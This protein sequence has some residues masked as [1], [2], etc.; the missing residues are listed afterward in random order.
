MNEIMY[1]KNGTVIKNKRSGIRW[2]LGDFVND[3]SRE[4]TS[5]DYFAID[6]VNKNTQDE[7][8]FCE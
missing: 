3:V 6:Y 7:Y 4:L 1:M 5:E 8:E 2:V